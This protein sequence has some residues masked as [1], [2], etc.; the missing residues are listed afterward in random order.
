MLESDTYRAILD[1]GAFKYLRQLVLRLGQKKF[2]PASDDVVRAVTGIADLDRVN[3]PSAAGGDRAAGE[4]FWC[5]YPE[6]VER[7]ERLLDVSS[8]Q[9]L[10]QSPE[11]ARGNRA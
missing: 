8:W 3:E 4:P 2:G 1:E 5:V 6:D 11:A 9:E 7:L 10:L